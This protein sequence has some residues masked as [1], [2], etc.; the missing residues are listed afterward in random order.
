MH[1]LGLEEIE[2]LRGQQDA[3]GAPVFSAD[4]LEWLAR[5]GT[6]EGVKIRAIPE[7]RAVH[8]NE[9]LTVVQ[10]PAAM[11][12]IL[13]TA[14]LNFLNY[15]TLIATKAARLKKAGA[16]DHSWNLGCVAPRDM[17]PRRQRARR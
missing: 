9:P 2:A 10:G 16:G 12:Q 17:P 4:F 3:N 13:E 8:P 6:F 5:H 15:Q 11:A 1:G 7:G 14:L